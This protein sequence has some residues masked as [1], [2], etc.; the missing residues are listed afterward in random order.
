MEIGGNFIKFTAIG[1]YLQADAP[2]W[3]AEVIAFCVPG[4]ASAV[5]VVGPG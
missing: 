1:V 3:S 2:E 5:L 4:S